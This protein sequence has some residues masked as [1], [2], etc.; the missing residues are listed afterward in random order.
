VLMCERGGMTSTVCSAKN[1]RGCE[2]LA[3]TFMG[4]SSVF[5]KA[6]F[7][8]WTLPSSTWKGYSFISGMASTI[9]FT[10]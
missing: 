9:I 7:S 10:R 3:V 6:M 1:M 8:L 2:D 5:S 4:V